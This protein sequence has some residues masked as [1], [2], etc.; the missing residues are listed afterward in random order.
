MATAA[1]R[2]VSAK[3]YSAVLAASSA[4][5][6]TSRSGC[7]VAAEYRQVPF[8]IW[9]H[10]GGSPWKLRRHYLNDSDRARTP[11]MAS[12][13]ID[14]CT[15]IST[16]VAT[17]DARCKAL[18][19]TYPDLNNPANTTASEGLLNDH[20]I[21][22]ATAIALAAASQLIASMQYPSRSILD[23]SYGVSAR[24]CPRLACVVETSFSSFSQRR[25]ALSPNPL[26]RRSYAR[27][28]RRCV[29]MRPAIG[30]H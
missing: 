10:Q 17:V 9:V 6:Q 22:N 12:S 14:L 27:R 2:H 4:P 28:A 29:F 21:A 23:A 13:L 19:G 24:S 3:F 11:T 20:E 26:P 18:A 16:S 8:T 1:Q 7:Q 30:G 15:L 5:H 25:W